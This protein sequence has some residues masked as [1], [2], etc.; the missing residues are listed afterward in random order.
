MIKKKNKER[1]KA[2]G[3]SPES[4]T[5]PLYYSK[6]F[7]RAG[8]VPQAHLWLPSCAFHQQV[9]KK[10][11]LNLVTMWI[12]R[13]EKLRTHRS[14]L[15]GSSY[16]FDSLRRSELFFSKHLKEAQIVFFKKTILCSCQTKEEIDHKIFQYLFKPY[17]YFPFYI[18]ANRISH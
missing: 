6:G 10:H 9:L 15:Q 3:S 11:M 7:L 8:L 17:N 12:Q 13:R 4:V 14:T 5:F 2:L 18:T 1:I 16:Q